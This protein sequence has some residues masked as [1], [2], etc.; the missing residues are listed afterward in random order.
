MSLFVVQGEKD[1]EKRRVL[2]GTNY[3]NYSFD[4]ETQTF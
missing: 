3:E 1:I 4:R 2:E